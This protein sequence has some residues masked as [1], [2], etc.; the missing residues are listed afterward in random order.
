MSH[1]MSMRSAGPVLLPD[2]EM[3]LDGVNFPTNQ[4][5]DS[6]GW[7]DFTAEDIQRLNSEARGKLRMARY[8]AQNGPWIDP[9]E[10]R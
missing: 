1:V 5:L 8:E 2:Q 6:D 10:M 4:Q 7:G 3:D 9:R